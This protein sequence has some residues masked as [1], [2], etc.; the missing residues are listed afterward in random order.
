M[1]SE[2][3]IKTHEGRELKPYR[4]TVGVLTIGYGRNLEKGI[5]EHIANELF[6]EDMV[7]VR[8]D[9]LKFEW[10]HDLSEVRQAVIEN[11]VFNLGYTRFS[12][13]KK[14]IKY[15]AASDFRLAAKEMLDSK[16]ARQVGY[17]ADELS[18][19]MASNLWVN[20]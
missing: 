4:D 5:S 11:M 13:F 1:K 6:K 9:C 3:L 10:F 15:I 19:M 12:K 14:T 16:W 8:S 2:D 17:R 18:H 20:E 7:D